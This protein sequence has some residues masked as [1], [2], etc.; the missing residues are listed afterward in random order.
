MKKKMCCIVRYLLL[1][2]S[3]RF[4]IIIVVYSILPMI[5]PHKI[6]TLRREQYMSASLT[7]VF[8]FFEQAENLARI[9]PPWLDFRIL[10]PTPIRMGLG[11]EIEYTIHWLGV[12]VRWYTRITDYDP[13]HRFVDEQLRGP[14]RQWRHLHSFNTDNGRTRMIDRVDYILPFG[15]VGRMAHTVLVRNQLCGIFDYRQHVVDQIFNK[16]EDPS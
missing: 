6:Y 8:S 7:T 5:M 4:I 13:P 12:P 16:K 11:T 14:Y 1:Y 15:V 2:S 10:T 3:Y 9:T